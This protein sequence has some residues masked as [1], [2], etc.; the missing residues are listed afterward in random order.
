MKTPFIEMEMSSGDAR[1]KESGIIVSLLF[2]CTINIP[3]EKSV[4]DEVFCLFVIL[5]CFGNGRFKL[6]LQHNTF[7]G[8]M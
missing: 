3:Q 4:L 6:L 7:I 1:R 8:I 5:F 2:I